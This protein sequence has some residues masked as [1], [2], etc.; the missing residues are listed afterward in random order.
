M[1][2]FVPNT[3]STQNLALMILLSSESL[4]MLP[5]SPAAVRV[6]AVMSVA[7]LLMIGLLNRLTPLTLRAVV[8][9]AAVL[10]K[11]IPVMGIN[12][13]RDISLESFVFLLK[14]MGLLSS[15]R[16]YNDKKEFL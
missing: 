10:K 9:V 16:S 8:R 13:Y 11:E 1:K 2:S 5:M 3:P 14:V 6:L 4:P 12:F 7:V 15:R